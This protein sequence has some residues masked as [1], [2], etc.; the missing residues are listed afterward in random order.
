VTH[1]S[2][3]SPDPSTRSPRA[4]AVEIVRMA[5]LI[6]LISG[7][8]ELG[9]R[10][11]SRKAMGVHTAIVPSLAWVMKVYASHATKKES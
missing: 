2:I 11:S 4:A 5:T 1:A 6:C 3:V 8:Q 7:L 10:L 9:K